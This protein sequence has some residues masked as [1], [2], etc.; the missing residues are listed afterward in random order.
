MNAKQLVAAVL[1]L[2]WGLTGVRAEAAGDSLVAGAPPPE[3]NLKLE[4]P[5]ADWF[6]GLPLGNGELGALIWGGGNS[7]TVRPDRL[8]LW[9]ERCSPR[10]TSPDFTW[11]T[12]QRWQAEGNFAKIDHL[13]GGYFAVPP[14][15]IVVG[16]LQ[17][18]FPESMRVTLFSLDL[19]SAEGRIDFGD[20]GQLRAIAP[21]TESVILLR[22]P[23]APVN[24]EWVAPGANPKWWPSLGY[25]E[26]V[27]GRDAAAVWYEQAI[28]ESKPEN[29]YF[30]LDGGNMIPGWKFVVYA[31]TRAVGTETLIALT[32]TSSLKDGADP[33]GAARRRVDRALERGCEALWAE[34]RKHWASFWGQSAVR[35][36]DGPILRHYYVT[37]YY[38]GASS[39]PGFPAMATL[40]SVWP[41]SMMERMKA[42]WYKNTI[43]NDVETE[44][45]YQSY[46]AA[47]HFAEGRV[48][49]DY[50]WEKLPLFRAYARTYFEAGGAVVPGCMSLGGTPTGSWPQY[51]MS[52]TYSGWFGWLFYQHWRYTQDREFL[53]TRAYPWCAEIAECWRQLLKPDAD[54]TLKLPLSSSSEIFDNSP[55]SWQLPN[56]N[57]DIHIMRTH[58][59]GLAEMG[60]ALG[61]GPEATR[62]R[63]IAGKLGPHPGHVD[64]EGALMWSANEKVT[65]QH[66]HL[67]HAMCIHPFNLL[68]VDGDERDR[69]IIA[70]TMKRFDK[71]GMTGCPWSYAWMSSMRS[72]V[73]DSESAYRHLDWF[74]RQCPSRNGFHLNAPM[75][76]LSTAQK[77]SS[78]FTLEA[79]MLAN[80]AVH[81]MLLQSWAPTIGRGEAGVVRLFPSTPKCWHEA[82]F[83][84]LRAEGGFRVSARRADN[85]TVWFKITADADGLLRVRDN[86]GGRTPKW[87]GPEMARVGMNFERPMRKGD[88]VEATLDKFR[89]QF[90]PQER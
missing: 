21:A 3:C 55:R 84:D 60:D 32:I 82:S 83:T 77:A 43:F 89:G 9:D 67:S 38:L 66:R 40:Q 86:F 34:H 28:P 23:R 15:H 35:I 54:G 72:R 62:W 47:G 69:A 75:A 90:N 24:A 11:K 31:E 49:L 22:S 70:A 57:Q 51:L 4:P 19:E 25:P 65:Q 71:T 5:V 1:L 39:K 58:L 52:P 30:R 59:L 10:A 63:G 79:N 6:E 87:S 81:D 68:N 50:L 20:A 44:A 41:D 85:A 17:L 61:K 33:L 48:F 78:F 74:V 8:D 16:K 13:Y 53:A 36:P 73:G 2:S 80:Q 64:E 76:G 26:P 46:Q 12:L 27:P 7:I 18:T 42:G 45:Q 56:S 37:R 88:V 29:T 14:T